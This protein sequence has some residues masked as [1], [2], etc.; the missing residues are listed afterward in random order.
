MKWGLSIPPPAPPKGDIAPTLL[1][2][3]GTPQAALP[4]T[5]LVV[6]STG[7]SHHTWGGEGEPLLGGE[8]GILVEK[9]PPNSLPGQTLSTAALEKEL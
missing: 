8:E 7:K 2:P 4:S 3:I 1:L 9:T 5:D 6:P